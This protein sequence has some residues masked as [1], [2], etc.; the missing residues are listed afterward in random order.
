MS[1][2]HKDIYQNIYNC[3]IRDVLILLFVRN[4]IFQE[5][6]PF[7]NAK[8]S[9]TL[10]KIDTIIVNPSKYGFVSSKVSFKVS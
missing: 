1:E 5:L 2:N 10:C 6:L 9:N 3:S 8:N 7:L 4:S